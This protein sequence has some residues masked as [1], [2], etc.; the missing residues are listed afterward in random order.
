MEFRV[1][2]LLEKDAGR[3][4]EMAAALSA[5]EGM[6]PPPFGADDVIRYAFGKQKRFDGI[7][8]ELD[9]ELIG[10][11]IFIDSF[12][13]GLGTPGLHMLDLYVEDRARGSGAGRALIGAVAAETIARGGSWVVWQSLPTNTVAIEFYHH[14]GSRQ[15]QAADFELSGITLNEMAAES[16]W[17]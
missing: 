5:H 7:V 10:Y 4:A 2:A 9:S 6:P 17:R 3:V 14:I 8:V 13:I 1:R 15:Y 16:S 12:N 11:T